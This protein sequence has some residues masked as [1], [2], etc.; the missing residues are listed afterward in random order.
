MD[1]IEYKLRSGGGLP[2]YVMDPATTGKIGPTQRWAAIVA[3]FA[4]TIT[5]VGEITGTDI[6]T[7]WIASSTTMNPVTAIM[8]IVG[9]MAI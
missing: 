1:Q 2:I 5:M 7:R 9:A 4:G 3:L 6:L 8:L